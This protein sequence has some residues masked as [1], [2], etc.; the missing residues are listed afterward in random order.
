MTIETAHILCY[1]PTR[2]TFATLQALASGMNIP[3]IQT[4][5][6]TLPGQAPSEETALLSDLAI[7]G[8]PVYAGRVAPMA[9]KRL[10]EIK[11]C[12]T[13]AVIVVV[14]GNRDY[15]GALVELKH[16]VEA[17]GFVVVAG[18]AFVGEHSYSNPEKPIGH[19]RPDAE[20]KDAAQ[21]FGASIMAKFN[22]MKDLS[23]LPPVDLP[24]NIPQGPYPGP[25]NI[26]PTTDIGLCTLCGLCADACP[27]GAI[28]V[29]E[30]H[31]TDA[32]RC[33]FCCACLKACPEGAIGIGLPKILAK[34]DFLHENF[35][36]RRAPELF[37]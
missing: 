13:P 29:T 7:I 9:A 25:A 3:A 4:L 6:L 16:L 32:S 5:D 2:T 8:V 15:E 28:T 26:A 36:E 14:Y 34:V 31:T 37:F 17:S 23:G 12:N 30:T 27:T 21:R 1:S 22:G 18:G 24:G 10:K 20:D 35:K 33:T 11:G 19:G